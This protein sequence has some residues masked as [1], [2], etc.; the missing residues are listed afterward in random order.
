MRVQVPVQQYWAL[1]AD[2]LGPQ[3]RRVALLAVLL[4]RSNEPLRLACSCGTPRS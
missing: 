3:W 2:Y 1:S 4:D